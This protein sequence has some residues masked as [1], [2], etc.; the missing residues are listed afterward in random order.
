MTSKKK[1]VT[2]ES[3]TPIRRTTPGRIVKTHRYDP[4]FYQAVQ[5]YLPELEKNTGAKPGVAVIMQTATLQQ[6]DWVRHRY[7]QLK[8]E[9]QQN[10]KANT[11]KRSNTD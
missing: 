3:L 4:D 6:V 8:K 2:Y 5:E 11:S 10:E 1:A 9:R 7:N